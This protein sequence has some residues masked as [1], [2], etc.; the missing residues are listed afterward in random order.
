MVT[1]QWRCGRAEESS[2]SIPGGGHSQC[3]GPGARGFRGPGAGVFDEWEGKGKEGGGG[4]VA[5]GENLGPNPRCDGTP[6]RVP[7]E[8][9]PRESSASP[10][11]CPQPSGVWLTK[12]W[13]DLTPDAAVTL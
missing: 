11:P 13:S 6:S 3:K 1:L 12:T 7:P 5:H 8:H 10:T 4:L 9:K 2:K